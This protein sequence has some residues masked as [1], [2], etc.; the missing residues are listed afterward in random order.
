MARLK[1]KVDQRELNK[2]EARKILLTALTSAK[3]LM[4]AYK[5]VALVSDDPN[6]TEFTYY[7]RD[8]ASE[9]SAAPEVE[10]APNAPE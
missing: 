2:L 7:T 9:D 6:E 3:E 1:D 8:R 4:G 5:V 10:E